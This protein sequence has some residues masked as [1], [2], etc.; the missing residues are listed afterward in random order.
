MYGYEPRTAA[1]KSV[2]V[3]RDND[4]AGRFELWS[5][6]GKGEL[7][8]RRG[9][10][11]DGDFVTK[12]DADAAISTNPVAKVV[13]ETENSTIVKSMDI[14]AKGMLVI[15]GVGTFG[16][17]ELH[18]ELKVSGAI[19]FDLDC[20][21]TSTNCDRI[22]LFDQANFAAGSVVDVQE[23]NKSGPVAQGRLWEV[24]V[25]G[26]KIIKANTGATTNDPAYEAVLPTNEKSLYVRK[27]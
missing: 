19:L 5:S 24:I 22:D 27:V 4:G 26:E 15:G 3:Q 1:K 8:A 7:I 13:T 17:L 6:A 2:E 20:A 9:I 12:L 21:A 11:V 23:K 10:S 16:V 18:G 14:G 25:S